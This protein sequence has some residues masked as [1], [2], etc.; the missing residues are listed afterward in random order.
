MSRE[1]LDFV[2]DSYAR[3][4]AGERTPQLWY[5]HEDAEYHASSEDPDSDV[6]RGIDAIRRQFERWEEAYPDLTVEPLEARE[7]GERVFLWVRFFGHGAG[8]GLPIDMELAHVLTLD[9]GR[10]RCVEEYTD[11]GQALRAMG[12]EE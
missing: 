12:L 3:Y 11:R 2:L 4:N 1:N 8:S 6:H 5:W 7:S 10:V 9:G